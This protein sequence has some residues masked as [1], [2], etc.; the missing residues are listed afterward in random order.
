MYRRNRIVNHFQEP[1]YVRVCKALNLTSIVMHAINV[2]FML[3][4][5]AL[6]PDAA[7]A[8]SS[9]QLTASALQADSTASCGARRK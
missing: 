8:A 5:F 2:V 3:V 7:P 4:E 1:V 9:R 6:D